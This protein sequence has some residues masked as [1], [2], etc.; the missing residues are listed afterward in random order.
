MISEIHQVRGRL[1]VRMPDLKRNDAKARAL[2]EAMAAECGI[3]SVDVNVLTG[4]LL[5][6]YDP[7]LLNADG[8][9][10]A[11]GERQAPAQVGRPALRGQ[12]AD[13]IVW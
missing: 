6:Y 12:I 10:A 8:V 1:R 7:E 11:I 9:L 13:A 5:V 2:K 3:M 4:S